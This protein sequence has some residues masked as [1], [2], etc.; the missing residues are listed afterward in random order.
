MCLK[1]KRTNPEELS[2]KEPLALARIAVACKGYPKMQLELDK[3]KQS[4]AA[5]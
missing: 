2:F 3:L 5:S 4:K 1:G